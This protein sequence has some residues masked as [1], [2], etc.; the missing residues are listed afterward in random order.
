MDYT[1]DC[2]RDPSAFAD[3][4]VEKRCWVEDEGAKE[5]GCLNQKKSEEKKGGLVHSEKHFEFQIPH[6]KVHFL[7][8]E[9]KQSGVLILT[10]ETVA[11]Y[12]TNKN[13]LRKI[14]QR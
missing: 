8:D 4:R 3:D 11:V 13:F 5:R 14:A 10:L 12:T 6:F 2:N 9:A 1:S 7:R